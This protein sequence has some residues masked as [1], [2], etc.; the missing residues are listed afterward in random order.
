MGPGV[1]LF[2]KN[3]SNDFY[4]F[5]H[6][7]INHLPKKSDEARFWKKKIGSSIK[8]E[9]VVKMMVFW[10][11]L[12]NGSNDF[13]KKLQNG[14]GDQY[15]AFAKNRRSRAISVLEIFIHKVEIFAENGKSGVQRSLYI[16][17]TVNATENLIRYSESTENFLS[18]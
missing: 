13:D 4:D 16:S 7:V 17:R 8:Y 11:F 2:L 6:E 12:K 9:N 3:G 15:E 5:L 1:T 10:L 18:R 14:R